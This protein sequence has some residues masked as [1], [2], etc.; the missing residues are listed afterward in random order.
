MHERELAAARWE[1]ERQLARDDHQ[2]V[3]IR[4]AYAALLEKLY[5][6]QSAMARSQPR[7][8]ALVDGVPGPLRELLERDGWSAELVRA[9]ARVA[10]LCSPAVAAASRELEG[11]LDHFWTELGIFEHGQSIDASV[12]VGAVR[13]FDR[14]L[15]VLEEAMRADV[16]S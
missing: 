3:E 2:A 9:N 13:E 1:H 16:R 6:W 5:E 8:P 4:E 11:W 15:V 10:T 12:V 14:C 7:D